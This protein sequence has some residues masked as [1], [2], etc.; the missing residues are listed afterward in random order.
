MWL[1]FSTSWYY[2]LPLLPIATELRSR[3][4]YSEPCLFCQDPKHWSWHW[5]AGGE[6]GFLMHALTG[7]FALTFLSA[8]LG[9]W[10]D[11]VTPVIAFTLVGDFPLS[12]EGPGGSLTFPL[13]GP[14]FPLPSLSEAAHSPKSQS[15]EEGAKFSLTSFHLL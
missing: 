15:F 2:C 1:C 3:A 5:M 12:C 14:S 6:G 9:C 10:I 8:L 4:A 11:E 7:L 13:M